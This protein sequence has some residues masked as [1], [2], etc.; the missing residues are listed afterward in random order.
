MWS[1]N[2]KN[3]LNKI[4]DQLIPE[5]SKRN[6]PSAGQLGIASFI[7]DV[8]NKNH[9]LKDDVVFIL[10]W[11]FA[12]ADK[13]S[14]CLVRKLEKENPKAFGSLLTET[15]KG[16]YSRSDIRYKLG[17]SEKPVHPSGYLVISESNDYLA[18]ITDTVR[19]RGPTYRDPTGDQR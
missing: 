19:A 16:Y 5:N 4:L 17:L 1:E 9:N 10:D 13:I 18:Q 14:P 3:I 15:Y 2:E 11:T 8:A 7:F 6:I 12:K